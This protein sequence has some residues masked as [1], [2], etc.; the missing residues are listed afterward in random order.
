MISNKNTKLPHFINKGYNVKKWFSVD[1]NAWK[2]YQEIID[3]VLNYSKKNNIIDH[4]YIVCA[5]PVSNVLIYN[6]HKLENRNI[7]LDL[8]SVMDNELG[9]VNGTRNYNKICGGWKSLAT[10]YWNKPTY[11]YQISCDSQSKSKLI[12]FILKII[13]FIYNILLHIIHYW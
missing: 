12:R 10:C 4:L 3:Q 7:Y 2:N 6:L 13:S 8:G 5:G 11:W 9:L 1:Y